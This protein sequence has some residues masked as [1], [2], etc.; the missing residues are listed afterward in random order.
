MEQVE[1]CFICG[2][3]DPAGNF[4][5]W[6]VNTERRTVHV[7]CWIAIY[8]NAKGDELSACRTP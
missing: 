7:G 2:K 3:S 1:K 6:V 4:G 5:L 8:E